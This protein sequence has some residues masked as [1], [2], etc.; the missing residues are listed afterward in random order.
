MC[1]VSKSYFPRITV[2][3]SYNF[4][5]PSIFFTGL[6]NV[7]ALDPSPLSGQVQKDL[8]FKTRK[9]RQVIANILRQFFEKKYN[10]SSLI[11]IIIDFILTDIL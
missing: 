10:E 11:L 5:C 2:T 3:V 1:G 9:D 7:L 8:L 4:I 6:L